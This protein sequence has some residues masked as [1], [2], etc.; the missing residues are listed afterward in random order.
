MLNEQQLQQI[1]S[2]QQH[3]EQA[4]G[5]S[6]KLNWEMLSHRNAD[7]KQDYLHYNHDNMLIGFLG[8]YRWGSQVEICGMVHQNYRRQGIFTSLW[9]QAIHQIQLDGYSL[10]LLNTPANSLSGEMF[11][12]SI[13]CKYENSEYQMKW[14]EQVGMDNPLLPDESI[15][16]DVQVSI[17]KATLQD[18]PQLIRLDLD[19][20]N[21]S[22]EDTQDL[23]LPLTEDSI[24]NDFMIEFNSLTVGKIRV[25]PIDSITWINAFTVD[26]T[27]RGQGIGRRA[28]RQVI[29]RQRSDDNSLWLEVAVH[30]PNA[31]HL[32]ES[33]GFIIQ[34]KQDYY[35]YT[36]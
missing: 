25:S 27:V 7:E 30:N 34:E 16:Q 4:D 26:A 9:T 36:G 29:E 28:L 8:V 14:D 1:Q 3:C 32:Y 12:K 18:V 33:C 15:S 23:Y 22:L 17:R 21:M 31:L 11:L 10:L 5:L 13:P 6:L 35:L 2:L 24:Q 20:F 19:G